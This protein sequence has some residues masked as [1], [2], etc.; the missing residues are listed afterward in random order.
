M[1]IWGVEFGEVRQTDGFTCGPTSVMIAGAL[2]DPAYAA[3][4]DT[5]AT[6]LALEQHRIHRAT[7]MIW[8]RR[9]GTTPW[10]VAAAISRHTAAFGVRYGWRFCGGRGDDLRDVVAAVDSGWPVALLI[11]QVVP[12]HWILLTGYQGAG[13]LRAYDPASGRAR[14]VGLDDIRHHRAHPGFPR[15]FALVL[16]TRVVSG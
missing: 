10:G 13:T 12:R 5:T 4:L 2:L 7:N 6:G 11:G 1:R 16:P 15:A 14:E 9:L 8:P 3:A